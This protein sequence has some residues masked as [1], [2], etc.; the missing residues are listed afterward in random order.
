MMGVFMG[1]SSRNRLRKILE[2]SGD[3]AAPPPS[4]PSPQPTETA[5]PPKPPTAGAPTWAALNDARVNLQE[6]RAKMTRLSDQ[7]ARGEINRM[8]FEAIYKHYQ[9]QLTRIEQMLYNVPGADVRRSAITQGMTG[10]LRARLAARILSYAIYDNATSMPLATVG[11]FNLDA[12]L[13]VPM[14]SSFRSATAEMFGAG[15]RSTEIEGGRWL[16]FVTGPHTTLIVLFSVEP[17]RLQLEMIEDLHRDF[18]I[19]NG[20]AFRRGEGHEA[21]Q[22]FTRIWALDGESA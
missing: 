15:M 6:L 21:A 1:D 10:V 12:D 5:S 2:G 9:E 17:A 19:A 4:I 13:L 3:S 11:Q 16:C 18:E 7:F 14:L 8:Q 20:P 22:S